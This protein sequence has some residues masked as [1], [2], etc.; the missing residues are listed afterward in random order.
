MQPTQNKDRPAKHNEI[1]DM[2]HHKWQLVVE[3]PI[4]RRET[5]EDMIRIVLFCLD[6]DIVPANIEQTKQGQYEA[7][8]ELRAVNN[9][10]GN[11]LEAV[12]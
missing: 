1:H 2:Y 10:M 3:Q 5:H 8:E 11:T 7:K 9:P 12:P 6:V 4:S